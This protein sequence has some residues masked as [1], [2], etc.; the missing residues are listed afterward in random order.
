MQVTL[1]DVQ[2]DQHCCIRWWSTRKVLSRAKASV[3]ACDTRLYSA[4]FD[5]AGLREYGT[6]T[7]LFVAGNKRGVARR[8]KFHMV[9]NNPR[10]FSVDTVLARFGKT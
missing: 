9:I 10:I 4:Q 6:S 3:N 5:S 1:T 2:S 7:L 8:R